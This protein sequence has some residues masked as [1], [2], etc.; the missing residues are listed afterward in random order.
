MKKYKEFIINA[1]PFNAEIISGVLWELDIEG[2][3]EEVGAL[4]V[5]APEDTNITIQTIEEKLNKL[6]EVNLLFNFTV[7]ENIVEEKNWNEEWE[8]NTKVIEISNFVIKPTFKDYENVDNKIII[9]IDPK[10]SF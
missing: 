1:E 5:F 3:N 9:E 4:T 2:T 10:M 7:E 8:K 6:K